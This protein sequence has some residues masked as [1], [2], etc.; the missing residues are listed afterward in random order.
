MIAYSMFWLALACVV[1]IIHRLV[2]QAWTQYR[3]D[4]RPHRRLV[5][6]PTGYDPAAANS[7]ERSGAPNQRLAVGVSEGIPLG[8]FHIQRAHH[9]VRAGIHHRHDRLRQRARKRR[10]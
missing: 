7:P 4:V 5:I 1:A 6:L 10:Q 9:R 2:G 8:V 3:W